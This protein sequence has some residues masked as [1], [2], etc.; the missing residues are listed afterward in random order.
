MAKG[1]KNTRKSSDK[2][3]DTMRIKRV[4]KKT[5]KAKDPKPN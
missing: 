3:R 2:K 4:L 5:N 1:K